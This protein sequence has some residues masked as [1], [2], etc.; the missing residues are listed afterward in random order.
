MYIA[1]ML[2]GLLVGAPFAALFYWAV[3]TMIVGGEPPPGSDDLFR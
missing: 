1:Y 3:W 2:L